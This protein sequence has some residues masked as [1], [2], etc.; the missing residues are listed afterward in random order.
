LGIPRGDSYHEVTGTI[1][2]KS[3]QGKLRLVGVDVEKESWLKET[4]KYFDTPIALTPEMTT[5]TT[6]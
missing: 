3:P 4:I 1:K 6:A 2:A 5:L